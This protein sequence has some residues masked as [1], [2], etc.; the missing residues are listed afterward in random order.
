MEAFKIKETVSC[1]CCAA[2]KMGSFGGVHKRVCRLQCQ[3][4]MGCQPLMECHS[5]MQT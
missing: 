5:D 2:H 1:L 3:P 4:L